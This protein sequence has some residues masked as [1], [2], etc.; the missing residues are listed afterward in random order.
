MDAFARVLAQ[1]GSLAARVALAAAWR[2][3]GDARADLIDKQLALRELHARGDFASPRPKALDR[4]I[5]EILA[6]HGREYAG[7][8]ADLVQAYEFRRGLVAHVTVSGERFP[9]IATEL[10][11]LAPIQ[12]LNLVE[13][14]G[15]LARVLA[16]PELAKLVTLEC[17][18][19]GDAFGDAGART[20]A[21]S[22]NVAGL[23]W[24][25]LMSDGIGEPGVEALAASPHLTNALYIDFDDNP[26]DPTPYGT[27][28]DG[29]SGSC[30]AGR[31]PLAEQ[32]ERTY[33]K[34]PWLAVP[35]DA[36][37][38]RR[39]DVAVTP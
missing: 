33:G 29:P 4:D 27:E 25:D 34:R 1:P 11:A 32:L 37:P 36:W 18:R 22:P 38:P 21:R 28:L 26:A 16:T 8:V 10:F 24:I 15:D 14:L 31:P 30:M 19:M 35:P 9:E 13:P 2:A 20:L 7:R 39:D 3:L 6:R 12:H 17:V 5:R 23:R